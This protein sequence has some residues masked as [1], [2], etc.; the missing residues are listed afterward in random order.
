MYR[1][2]RILETKQSIKHNQSIDIPRP[3]TSTSKTLRTYG[4]SE[5]NSKTKLKYNLTLDDLKSTSTSNSLLQ[6]NTL[7]DIEDCND[8]CES[9]INHNQFRINNIITPTAAN[10]HEMGFRDFK[11]CKDDVRDIRPDRL[12]KKVSNRD[13]KCDESECSMH[14]SMDSMSEIRSC[15]ENVHFDHE[16]MLKFKEDVFNKLKVP[17]NINYNTLKLDM[18]DL[19]AC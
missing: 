18:I 7:N 12:Y 5:L 11:D 19:R 15:I 8:Q 2:K 9:E 16:N 14:A 17:K 10:T 4:L 1:K 13:K 6:I 3:K